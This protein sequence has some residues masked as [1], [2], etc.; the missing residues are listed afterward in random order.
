MRTQGTRVRTGIEE[1]RTA[2]RRGELCAWRWRPGRVPARDGAQ[3]PRHRIGTTASERARPRAHLRLRAAQQHGEE[4][5]AEG[6]ERGEACHWKSERECGVGMNAVQSGRGGPPGAR[7]T[8]GAR[9]S[10]ANGVA[11]E[12]SG[13]VATARLVLPSVLLY[14]LYLGF[15]GLQESLSRNCP[16]EMRCTYNMI[17]CCS[18]KR[19]TPGDPT[20]KASA[21]EQPTEASDVRLCVGAARTALAEAACAAQPH[22]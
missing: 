3:S 19:C 2:R 18:E 20:Q 11:R 4:E 13:A 21:C 14:S 7:R 16:Q 15:G 1:E 6:E 22:L 9:G 8:V 12:Q 10:G 17:S 5:Q